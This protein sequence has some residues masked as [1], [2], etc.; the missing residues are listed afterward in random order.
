MRGEGAAD[1]LCGQRDE[2]LRACARRTERCWRTGAC[3]G[4]WEGL[5]ADAGR[6]GSAEAAMNPGAR[7]GRL[8]HS[9]FLQGQWRSANVEPSPE[10]R[11]ERAWARTLFVQPEE[12]CFVKKIGVLFGMENTFPA[13]WWRRSTGRIWTGLRRSL[14][15]VGAVRLDQAAGVVGDCG[16]HLAR[17]SVLPGVSETRGAARDDGHQ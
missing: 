14:W 17:Y 3:R 11:P 4:C 9:G 8:F 10:A 2:L 6:A 7:R 1:S 15:R 12:R 13:R 16:S 5:A